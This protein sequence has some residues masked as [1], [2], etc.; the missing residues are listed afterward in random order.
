MEHDKLLDRIELNPRVMAGKPVIKGT[1]LI[2][3]HILNLLGH[4][5]TIDEILSEYKGLTREDVLA[6]LQYASE[7]LEDITF[8]PLEEADSSIDKRY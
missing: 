8:M 1:R 7:T 4:G 2:V 3:Q 5:V 6:C